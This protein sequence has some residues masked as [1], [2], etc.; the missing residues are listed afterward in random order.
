M[1]KCNSLTRLA[2]AKINLFLHIIE[3][4]PTGFHKLQSLFAFVDYG[5]FVSVSKGNTTSFSI[6]GPFANSLLVADSAPNIIL[7]AVDWFY[8]YFKLQ[9]PDLQINLQKN[10]PIAS[11]IGGGSTDAAAVLSLLLDLENIPLSEEAHNLFIINSGVLGADVPVCL[12][13]QLDLGSLFWLD[14]SGKE[15]L[16][17]SVSIKNPQNL[18]GILINPLKSIST[19]QAFSGISTYSPL[20]SPQTQ[21]NNTSDFFIFLKNQQNDFELS[22]GKVVPEINKIL[23]QMRA[24]PGCQLAQLSGSGATCFAL[25]TEKQTAEKALQSLKNDFPNYWAIL[26]S[27]KK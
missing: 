3:K 8:T 13:H 7:K 17:L 23:K 9:K 15:E 6:T 1:E 25:F 26:T 22:S 4:L 5:D 21:F 11:G 27:L 14:G 10:L 24:K 2:P 16:P 20:L 19:A 18:F 12:Y